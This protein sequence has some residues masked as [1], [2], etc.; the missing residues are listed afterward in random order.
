MSSRR[1]NARAL[2]R[3]RL[4]WLGSRALWR[5][6]TALLLC[7]ALALLAG[8][9]HARRCGGV[10]AC[11][12]KDDNCDG[13]VDEGFLDAQGR[14][15]NSENCGRC[16]LSCSEVFPTAET[17]RCD[18][19]AD[20]PICSLVAC[21]AGFH[22]VDGNTCVKDEVTLCLPC[23]V[24]DDCAAR[25]AGALCLELPDQRRCGIPCGPT[26]ACPRPFRCDSGLGQ[27]VPEGSFCAC[28]GVSVTVEVACLAR[29]SASDQF[30]AGVATCSARGLS[31]CTISSAES[32]DGEDNDCDG[33]ADEDF[34]DARGRYVGRLHCGAC[35]QACAPP[36]E[37]YEA[38]CVATATSASCQIA[39][40][41][42]FVDVDGIQGNGCEC[43]RFD[44]SAAPNASGGDNNCD[45]VIDDDRTYVHVSTGGNDNGAGTLLAPLRSIQAGIRR[46]AMEGKAVLVAQGNYDAFELV[47]GVNVFGGYR[48]D[49]ATR[50]AALYA[51]VVEH[52]EPRD[53]VPVLGCRNIDAATALDGL[54]FVGQDATTQGAG[55]TAVLFDNCGPAVKLSHVT[56][57]AGRGADGARGVDAANRLPSGVGS[58]A[59]LTGAEGHPGTPSRSV[60]AMNPNG[61]LPGGALGQKSCGGSDVSG[62]NGG[63]SACTPLSCLPG[64]PC[65][66]AGC[67]DFTIAGVCD[68]AAVL[69]AA[70]PNPVA[71]GGRGSAAGAPGEVTYNAPTTRNSCDFCDDNPTLPRLGADGGDGQNGSAGAGG[72][73]CSDTSVV[74]DAAARGFGVAGSEGLSGTDGSGGGGGSAGSGFSVTAGTTG[75][76]NVP[77]GSGGSGGSGGCGAPSGAAGQGGGAS[78]GVV[79]RVNAQGAG[80][81][82]ES[83]RV[84]T[85]SGGRGGDGGIGAAGGSGGRGAAG[86]DSTFW[87]ARSGGRGGDGGDGGAGGGGGG[88]CGGAS[89]AALL[90]GSASAAYRAQLQASLA[91]EEAGV[92][93]QGG[94]GG[95]S[96]GFSGGVGA[97][98]ADTS[99]R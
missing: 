98:G 85:E 60:C 26:R 74:L 9:P 15:V 48:S 83:V 86:G 37:H 64:Q 90:A 76:S 2:A 13:R 82:F 33:K 53:G 78:L 75:C 58:L 32:C 14:Y 46:G 11:N 61:T 57:L 67:T 6:S 38:N 5:A 81:T 24:D 41:A 79:V 63:D 84:V 23:E 29:G 21:A 47:A 97:R 18:T 16:G 69:R 70:T 80:P 88:G 17:T 1:C 27:C 59:E 68:Y 54:T 77:G 65:G 19:S 66:N 50:D 62:G 22:V 31:E 12:G 40:A 4:A 72:F 99:V 44:G 56:V 30:C 51:V 8:C 55:S 95:F 45:G 25:A 89:H 39:C 43:Q 96:P 7:T 49:F 73:G 34:V 71:L 3:A 87:C 28:Q 10:E 93:G 94:R 20:E 36:G 35:N 91:V 92:S 42:G 52:Q